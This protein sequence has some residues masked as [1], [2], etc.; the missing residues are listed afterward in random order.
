MLSLSI[1]T[2][3]LPGSATRYFILNKEQELALIDIVSWEVFA[4]CLKANLLTLGL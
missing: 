2:A 3:S 1:K 4:A